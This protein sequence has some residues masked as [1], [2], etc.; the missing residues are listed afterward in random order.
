VSTR[1]TK[2]GGWLK[3]EKQPC[4]W[5]GATVEGRRV[6]FCSAACVHEWKLRTSP[7]YLRDQV[8]ARDRG[9]CAACGLDTEALRK[10]KRKLDWRSRRE[11]E[12]EWGGRRNLWDADHI[13]PVV[14]GGGECDLSNMRTLC[15]RCHKAATAELQ[16]RRSR[17][18][19]GTAGASPQQEGI[20]RSK[21][22]HKPH[23]VEN[24]G[25]HGV[26]QQAARGRKS[27]G[28]TEGQ[29]ARDP[30]G[31]KGQFGGAGDSPLIK[32]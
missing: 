31:R 2:S 15:L 5:C 9:V 14:E 32:K 11:F 6:T 21:K 28:Q 17:K 7:G 30:K 3:R 13:V 1:R 25:V 8:F 27:A 18:P 23:I 16:K 19:S 22:A 20:M 29:F 10:D 26:H 12:R 24:A 4:R